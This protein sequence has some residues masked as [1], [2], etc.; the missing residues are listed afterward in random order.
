M[1]TVHTE[2]MERTHTGLMKVCQSYGDNTFI[3]SSNYPLSCFFGIV[4]Q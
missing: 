2:N 1:D 4:V 3:S